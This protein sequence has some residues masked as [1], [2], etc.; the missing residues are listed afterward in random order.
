MT[1]ETDYRGKMRAVFL[2]AI[3]LTS[4]VGGTMAFTGAAAAITGPAS[5]NDVEYESGIAFQGQN[6]QGEMDESDG[7]TLRSVSGF[8]SDGAIEGT[9]FVEELDLEDLDGDGDLDDD[10]VVDTDDLEAGDYIVVDDDGDVNL[11]RDNTFEVTV[12]DLSAEFEEDDLPAI[13]DEFADSTAELDVSSARNGYSYNVS[14]DGDLERDQLFN[15][16]TSAQLDGAAYRGNNSDF[17]NQ[18]DI[19]GTATWVVDNEGGLSVVDSDDG[20]VL[21]AGSTELSYDSPWNALENAGDIPSG[22]FGS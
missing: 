11:T 15:L 20:R 7:A 4:I 17:D 1:N 9:S 2:A 16:F 3:M 19:N 21:Q 12:Q 14:A 6:I 22:L 18:G 13:T 10:F 5:V 8:D